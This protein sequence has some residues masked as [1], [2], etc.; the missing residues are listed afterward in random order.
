MAPFAVTWDELLD[1]YRSLGGVAENVRLGE[2]AFGRGIFVIDPTR[3]ARL[4][5]PEAMNVPVDSVVIR[6]GAM[7]TTS[8]DL[9][10]R[11][12][13]FFEAYERYFGWSAGGYDESF[14]LQKQ[15]HELPAEVV[16][17]IGA[18]SAGK[19]HQEQRRFLAPS[20]DVCRDV[21]LK[22][23]LFD[24]RKRSYVVPMIDLVNH[25]SDAASYGFTDG[26]SVSGTFASEMLVSYNTADSWGQ[27]LSYGF[28]SKS[29]YAYSLAISV[30][31]RNG[32]KVSIAR[33]ITVTVT[34]NRMRFPTQE[35]NG[36]ETC[37]SFLLLG[38]KAAMD[39]PRT[40]FRK[41]TAG[42]LDVAEADRVFDGIQH[43]N[44][45]HFIDLLR[46]LR[47]CDMPLARRLEEVVLDQLEALSAYVGSRSVS[48]V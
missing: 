43:Y 29:P 1:F 3:P 34:N 12:R 26:F 25:S 6:D 45:T 21:Y 31:Q 18:I 35:T 40:T 22:A 10:T 14:A 47:R 9:G 38:Y 17:A 11:E 48:E 28:A 4:F 19:T 24:L 36:N 30:N 39:L 32:R 27:M 44:R 2:G 8:S 41:L 33:D 42:Y 5:T 7:T 15:W 46:T 13:A 23:R 20:V 37:L 16:E